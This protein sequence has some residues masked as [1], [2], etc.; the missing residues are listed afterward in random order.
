MTTSWK[1]SFF[2]LMA[3]IGA[4]ALGALQLKPDFFAG[5]PHWLPGA[6]LLLST[7]GTAGVG[8]AARDNDKTSEDVGAKP[9]TPGSLRGLATAAVLALGLAGVLIGC[10]STPAT[11]AYQTEATTVTSADAAMNAWGAY[12]AQFH[13]P[14]SQEAAVKAAYLKY[15]AAIEAV[16]DASQVYVTLTASG[17]TN[18]VAAQNNVAAVTQLASQ[19]FANLLNVIKQFGVKL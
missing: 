4:A 16:I 9:A 14:A 11:V 1:T 2:G 19:A 13:P 7:I 5:W 8:L 17:S 12:V 18:T 3:A 10:I 15:Q 6:A